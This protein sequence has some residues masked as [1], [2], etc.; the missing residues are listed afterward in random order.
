[1][2]GRRHSIVWG[3]SL[4]ACFSVSA[5]RMDE[6][7]QALLVGIG[8]DSV[9]LDLALTPGSG[10]AGPVVRLID[11]DGDLRISGAEGAAYARSLTG[12]LDLELDGR[13]V[14]LPQPEARFAD[15]E[16]MRDGTGTSRMIWNVVGPAFKPGEHRLTLRNRHLAGASVYLANALQPESPLVSIQGQLR[17]TNQSELTVRFEVS[18]PHGTAQLPATSGAR[19]IRG[20]VMGLAALVV[21]ASAW[22]RRRI[23]RRSR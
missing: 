13:H 14:P 16:G 22:I 2:S 19:M 18:G 15:V 10:M 8:P 21:V 4:A 12:D 1:V 7:L 11:S 6:Y 5:H 3:L 17:N 23:I 9:T 20:T